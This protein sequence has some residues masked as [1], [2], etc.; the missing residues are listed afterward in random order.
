MIPASTKSHSSPSTGILSG[1]EPLFRQIQQG[2]TITQLKNP[3]HKAG[4]PLA[5]LTL[6]L[7]SSSCHFQGPRPGYYQDKHYYWEA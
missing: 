2:H 7:P 1:S 4:A 5:I 3:A 6:Q